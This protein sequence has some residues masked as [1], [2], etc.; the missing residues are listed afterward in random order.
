MTVKLWTDFKAHN[1]HTNWISF[2]YTQTVSLIEPLLLGLFLND[3]G[4]F[5]SYPSTNCLAWPL[6]N[7]N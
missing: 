6:G 2:C 5:K 3:S 7:V 4:F 1:Q